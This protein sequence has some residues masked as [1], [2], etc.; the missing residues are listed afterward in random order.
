MS[1]HA[2][3]CAFG[4]DIYLDIKW[5]GCSLVCVTNLIDHY[6]AKLSQSGCLNLYFTSVMGVSFAS[7]TSVFITWRLSVSHFSLRGTYGSSL[8]L[9]FSVPLTLNAFHRVLPSFFSIHLPS[10][11][12]FIKTQLSQQNEKELKRKTRWWLNEYFLVLQ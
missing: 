9:H 1:P 7:C 10:L 12:S 8:Y 2:Y 11:S 5:L 6:S 4:L 3:I